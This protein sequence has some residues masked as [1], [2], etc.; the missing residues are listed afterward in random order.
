MGPLAQTS[1]RVI[2]SRT[3]GRVSASFHR[4]GWVDHTSM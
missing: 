2:R 3:A 1:T 4:V